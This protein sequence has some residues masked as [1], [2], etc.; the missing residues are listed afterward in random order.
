LEE[1]ADREPHEAMIATSNLEDM[2][3]SLSDLSKS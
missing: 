1:V 3:S 2:R